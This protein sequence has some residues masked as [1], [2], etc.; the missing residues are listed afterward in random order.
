MADLRDSKNKMEKLERLVLND[1]G[2]LCRSGNFYPESKMPIPK[3]I[4]ALAG[5]IKVL[6]VENPCLDISKIIDE[7]TE[8]NSAFIP[9]NANSYL[10]SDFNPA[11]Q[12]IKEDAAGNKKIYSDYA[13]QFY[14]IKWLS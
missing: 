11:A 5:A 9:E 6:P 3:D 2:E 12:Y 1:D 14:E 7:M 13:I 4:I 8:R 10:A